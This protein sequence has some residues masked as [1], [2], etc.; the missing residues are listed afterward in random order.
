MKKIILLISMSSLIITG[1]SS[2]EETAPTTT[3]VS[4]VGSVKES[5]DKGVSSDDKSF[6]SDVV[7]KSSYTKT[8]KFVS[9]NMNIVKKSGP[10]DVTLNAIQVSELHI[11]DNTDPM[12]FGL[13]K[14]KKYAIVQMKVDVVNTSE[15]TVQ[16]HM[17]TATLKTNGGNTYS[18]SL[19]TGNYVYSGKY[20]NS[21]NLQFI[22]KEDDINNLKKIELTTLVGTTDDKGIGIAG[23]EPISI[24]L[25][26]KK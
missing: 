23:A 16:F 10:I 20:K 11:I 7:S 4:T 1:C 8:P 26:I 2:K 19:D 24:T 21:V 14:D 5:S 17:S 25:D 18:N 3:T 9:N 22:L 13:E 15:D 6:T 12:N